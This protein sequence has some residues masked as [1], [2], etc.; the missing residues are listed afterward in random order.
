LCKAIITKNMSVDT[1]QKSSM[2]MSCTKFT[3][4]SK[5]FNWYVAP[6]SLA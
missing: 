1:T 5:W 3:S 4:N 6:C 2:Q